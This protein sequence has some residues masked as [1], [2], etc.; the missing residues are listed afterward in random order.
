MSVSRLKRR[1]ASVVL[2]SFSSN[3]LGVGD[4][5]F[6]GCQK[7]QII[8]M[9]QTSTA[10]DPLWISCSSSLIWA[11][12][13]ESQDI[14]FPQVLISTEVQHMLFITALS[15]WRHDA[16]PLTSVCGRSNLMAD[17]FSMLKNPSLQAK[18]SSEMFSFVSL[19]LSYLHIFKT[20]FK[21]DFFFHRTTTLK[22]KEAK[23]QIK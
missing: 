21:I 8:L 18:F 17:G 9:R 20:I 16:I 7:I 22:E 12:E 11:L 1:H 10:E 13:F 6:F 3:F 19:Q 4:G 5:F 2:F 15:R 23:K 14:L